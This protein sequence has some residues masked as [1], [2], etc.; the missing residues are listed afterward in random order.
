[1]VK[2]RLLTIAD[3]LCVMDFVKCV[4]KHGLTETLSEMKRDIMS[5]AEFIDNE[6]H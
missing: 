6:W 5:I 1:M 4:D 2:Q 3:S